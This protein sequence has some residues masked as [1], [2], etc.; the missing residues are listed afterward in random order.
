ML[1]NR[2]VNLS[3]FSESPFS[4]ATNSSL[5]DSSPGSDGAGLELALGCFVGLGSVILVSGSSELKAV[6]VDW[7]CEVV[8]CGLSVTRPMKPKSARPV[9]MAIVFGFHISLAPKGYLANTVAG[10][11]YSFSGRFYSPSS[12]SSS[13]SSILAFIHSWT[14]PDS[15]MV[16][17]SAMA[18][19]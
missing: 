14:W 9:T 1:A 8:G 2:N 13:K 3:T 16:I 6:G 10:L 17:I 7:V 15:R 19:R 18:S 12:G 4:S 5:A 11:A